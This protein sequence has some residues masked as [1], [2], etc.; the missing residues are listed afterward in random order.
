MTSQQAASIAAAKLADV[1]Q[2]LATEAK[3]HLRTQKD[4]AASLAQLQCAQRTLDAVQH[5]SKFAGNASRVLRADNS[6][7]Q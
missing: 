3:Q 5:A 7:L 2:D 1:Q 4:A 6:I